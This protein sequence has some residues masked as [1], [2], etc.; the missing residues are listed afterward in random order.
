MHVLNFIF[1]IILCMFRT[2]KEFLSRRQWYMPPDDEL[3]NYPTHVEDIVKIK[4][5]KVHL[6]R[7]V[8]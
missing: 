4:T 7:S 8:K 2:H 3:L 5:Q 6:V 1:D